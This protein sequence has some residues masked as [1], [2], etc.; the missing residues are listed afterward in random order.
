M[1]NHLSTFG[2]LTDSEVNQVKQYLTSRTIQKG[3]YLITEG[4]V[5]QEIAYVENGTLRSFYTKDNGE[6]VTYCITFAGNFTTAYSSYITGEK[7]P[8]S[9]QA[10]SHA[11][12]LIL[13]KRDIETMA[14]NSTNWVKLLKFLAEQQYVEMEKRIFSYQKESA[15]E[16][17]LEL[18]KNHPDYIQNIPLQYLASYLGIT[19]RHLSR[20]RK[21]LSL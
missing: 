3:E 18:V 17:Y 5:C 21:E 6:E 13:K 1:L 16:R 8:E 4:K 2:I 9:I 12:L 10:L 15:N 11:E 20:I 14:A 7:T 19:P